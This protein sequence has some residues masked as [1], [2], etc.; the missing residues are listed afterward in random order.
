[1]KTQSADTQQLAL[2]SLH[3]VLRL[4]Q[5]AAAAAAAQ[6]ATAAPLQVADSVWAQWGVE[7]LA[8]VGRG[9]HVIVRPLRPPPTPPPPRRAAAGDERT[10][11]LTRAPTAAQRSLK[12][13][14]ARRMGVAGEEDDPEDPD[15]LCDGDQ[16]I[17]QA[18]QPTW[19]LPHE[20]ETPLQRY[21]R[22][23]NEPVPAS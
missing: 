7:P 18:M 16:G 12:R 22:R 21:V 1:M 4:A 2:F 23:L 14:L 15:F 13:A 11:R 8:I 5:R 3:D 6:P 20:A 10:I 17:D 9:T 19:T